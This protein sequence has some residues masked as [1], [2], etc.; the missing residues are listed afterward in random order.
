[1]TIDSPRGVPRPPWKIPSGRTLST[2]EAF[3]QSVLPVVV[4]VETVNPWPALQSVPGGV[5]I[6]FDGVAVLLA[7]Y[8]ILV[9]ATARHPRFAPAWIRHSNSTAAPVLF[10]AAWTL[11]VILG[12]GVP[13]LLPGASWEVLFWLP[14]VAIVLWCLLFVGARVASDRGAQ[15][16]IRCGAAPAFTVSPDRAWWWEADHWV[17]L[18]EAAPA[19]ALRSPDGNYWW[20]DGWLPMPPRPANA[21]RARRKAAAQA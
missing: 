4:L 19:Q 18:V 17:P 20:A 11:A 14:G 9:I 21:D 15:R 12:R 2:R 3:V 1:M 6:A 5:T 8:G 7:L 16:A 10:G 13:L